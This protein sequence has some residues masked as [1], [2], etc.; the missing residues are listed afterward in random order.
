MKYKLVKGSLNAKKV[1]R[2]TRQV[3]MART[4]A[5]FGSQN[6]YFGRKWMIGVGGGAL[7]KADIS[8]FLRGDMGHLVHNGIRRL[9]CE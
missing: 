5:H 1:K 8:I 9:N 2:N 7:C 6:G 3:S 4:D